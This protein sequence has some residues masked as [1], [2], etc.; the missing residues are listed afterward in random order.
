MES[1]AAQR[2]GVNLRWA[3][4]LWGEVYRRG[5]EVKKMQNLPKYR[6]YRKV[7]TLL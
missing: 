4:E 6:P 2:Q 5:D 3:R 7:P 1:E